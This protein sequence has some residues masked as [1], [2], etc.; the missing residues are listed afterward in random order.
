MYLNESCL[1]ECWKVPPTAKLLLVSLLSVVG[2]V[3]EKLNK[4][5]RL[6]DHLEKFGL[7]SNFQ[8]GFRSFQSTANLQ[9]Y[10]IELFGLLIGLGLHS[11]S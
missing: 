3:F 6:I 7:F 9:L 2:K 10:M 8:Y 11:W 1:P 4:N 5:N